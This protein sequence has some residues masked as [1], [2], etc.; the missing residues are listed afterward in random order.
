[1]KKSLLVGCV[2][3]ATLFITTGCNTVFTGKEREESISV[4]KD[5]AEEL[6]VEL[7]LGVGELTVTKGAKDWV[8]GTVKYNVNDLEPKVTYKH[9]NH[10]GEVVIKQKELT[11]LD[12]SNIKN[13][14]DLELSDAIPMNLT[15]NSGASDTRLDLQGFQLE[16]LDINT[17]VGDL[18]VDLGGDW[19][20]SF[21]ANIETG[22]GETT[23]IL[24]SKVG[25]KITTDK[26]IGTTNIEGFISKGNGVYVNEAYKDADVILTVHTDTGI[27]DVTFELDE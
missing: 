3:V 26:G 18:A 17:G 1:M 27:G 14:W 22:V 10:K 2:I 6:D 7:N 9:R 16:S 19:K 8:E 12:I 21:E 23:V 15:V 20:K 13:E 11:V 25:V 5:I 4:K 24:P